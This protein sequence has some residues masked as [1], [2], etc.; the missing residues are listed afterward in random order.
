MALISDFIQDK[1]I[2][3]FY[4]VVVMNPTTKKWGGTLYSVVFFL[5]STQNQPPQIIIG[6]S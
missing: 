2:Y 6:L 3:K 1:Q 5:F 4:F